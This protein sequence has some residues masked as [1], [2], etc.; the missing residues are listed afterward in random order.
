MHTPKYH[1]VHLLVDGHRTACGRT[2]W[3]SYA[4]V[5][6]RDRF[7]DPAHRGS[8]PPCEKCLRTVEPTLFRPP[9]KGGK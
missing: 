7:L 3:P 9:R 8:V 1:R 6:P 5:F 2:W 4:M